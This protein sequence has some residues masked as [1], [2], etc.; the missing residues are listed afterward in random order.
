M[1]GMITDPRTLRLDYP[2]VH[3][4]DEPA[5]TRGKTFIAPLSADES[6][7]VELEKGPNIVTLPQFEVLPDEF[8]LEVLLKVGDDISTRRDHAPPELE[9]FLFEA[10]SRRS[11][12]S[13][14]KSSIIPTTIALSIHASPV[15]TP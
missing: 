14:S 1:T 11:A 4:S 6:A 3:E 12:S 8:D 5:V 9:F 15:V 2:R 10:I 7:Q 13:V